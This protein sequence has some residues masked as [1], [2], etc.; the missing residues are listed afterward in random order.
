MSDVS[1]LEARRIALAAQGFA[2]PLPKKA[3]KRHLH[4]V[5]SRTGVLQLDSVNIVARPQYVVPFARIGAYAPELLHEIAYH[6]R[7]WFEYNAHAAS[8]VAVDRYPL[9]RP[10]MEMHRAHLHGPRSSGKWDTQIHEY[11]KRERPYMDA[12][13]AE[14]TERGALSAGQLSEAGKSR[15]G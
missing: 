3:T 4:R 5:M 11:V 12:I 2:D 13:L 8:L 15:P 10:R 7:A 6:D 14:I 9:F 1:I